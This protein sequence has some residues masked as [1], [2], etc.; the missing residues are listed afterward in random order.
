M[1][2]KL[3]VGISL[4]IIIISLSGCGESV[5][6]KLYNKLEKTVEI[7]SESTET[8]KNIAELEIKD[9]ELLN[10]I[11]DYTDKQLDEANKKSD[12]AIEIN[13]KLK[14]SLQ[15]EESKFAEAKSEFEKSE[16]LI[17][18]LEEK[19]EEEL[20]SEMY[21]VMIKRYETYDKLS[22]EYEVAINEKIEFYKLMKKED[23]EEE[24]LLNQIEK[25]NKHNEEIIELNTTINEY[26]EEYNALKKELYE[27]M[28]LNIEYND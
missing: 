2:S 18:K 21:D 4:L 24:P 22:E 27:K 15:E 26:T 8:S 13:E 28:D 14:E 6:E 20:G 5:E 19:N 11:A 12:E 25:I 3:A 1:K 9:K 23:T 10:E 7:E 17:D 16:S